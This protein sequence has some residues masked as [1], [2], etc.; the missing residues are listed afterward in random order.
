MQVEQFLNELLIAVVTVSSPIV[1]KY[2]TA[3]LNTLKEKK[4]S[5][6]A[7][8]DKVAFDA[9]ILEAIELVQKVVDKVSQTYVDSLKAK[10]EFTK[11]A[12][13]SSLAKAIDD[14]KTLI[15]AE[16]QGLISSVYSDFDKWL[17][18]QIESYIRSQK[19]DQA[20][21]QV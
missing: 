18:I 16:T 20:K 10:N 3:Y 4:K 17:E 13:A 6:I 19:P 7:Q 12:Q 9:S 5:E 14:A 2:I 11:E 1:V 8:E 15:S 21:P